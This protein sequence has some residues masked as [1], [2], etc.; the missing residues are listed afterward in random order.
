MVFYFLTCIS[1]NYKQK[2]LHLNQMGANVHTT[3]AASTSMVAKRK[4]LRPN[5][6]TPAANVKTIGADVKQI[7]AK[8]KTIS[9]GVKQISVDVKQFSA[10][11]K[12]TVFFCNCLYAK[13][14]LLSFGLVSLSFG[15]GLLSF[16]LDC[17]TFNGARLSFGYGRQRFNG[18]LLY[19]SNPVVYA[20]SA[21][22]FCSNGWVS[23]ESGLF[24]VG[25]RTSFFTF[26]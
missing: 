26:P 3:R 5:V 12:T 8:R 21:R 10:H 2:Q 7:V 18:D 22:V 25:L 4:T 15:A 9:A 13:Y 20:S 23:F 16:G 19:V 17:P 14:D 11:V 6:Y 1:A 24:Y